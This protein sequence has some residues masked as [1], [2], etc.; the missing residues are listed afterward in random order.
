VRGA[1][2]STHVLDLAQGAPVA[3]VD[4]RLLDAQ[5]KPAGGGLTDREG[6]LARLAPEGGVPPGRY[7]LL[8][9][10]EDHFRERPH[11]LNA[12]TLDIELSEARHYHVP[13]LIAPYACS[14]YRGS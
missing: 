5:G 8:F 12:V 7:R 6:R 9:R 14:T 2:I 11:L 3:N 4:V 1:T 13:L 10:V